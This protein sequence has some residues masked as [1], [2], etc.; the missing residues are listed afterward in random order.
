MTNGTD[1]ARKVELITI[2]GIMS[3]NSGRAVM[4]SLLE[5]SGVFTDTFDADTHI[6][7]K[8]AGKREIGLHLVRELKEASFDKYTMMIKEHEDGR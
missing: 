1:D 8:N 6:H 2:D 7:A 4:M 3:S 5:V